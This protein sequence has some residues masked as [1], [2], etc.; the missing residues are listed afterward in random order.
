VAYLKYY[1]DSAKTRGVELWYLTTVSWVQF[2]GT[3]HDICGGQSATRSR[4][5][6][7]ALRFSPENLSL[8]FP[9]STLRFYDLDR[10]GLHFRMH[11][12]A[13]TTK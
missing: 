7:P 12:R 6:L 5:S 4:F 13:T 11:P 10:S 1:A 3:L 8:I 2:Q 9:S